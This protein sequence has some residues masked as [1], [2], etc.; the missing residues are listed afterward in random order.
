MAIRRRFLYVLMFTPPAVLVSAVAGATAAAAS[1]GMFWLFVFGD[2]PWPRWSGPVIAVVAVT[3]FVVLLA[4]QLM[5]AWSVGTQQ[6]SKRHINRTH[7]AVAIVSTLTLAAFIAIRFFAGQAPQSHSERS[8]AL[9]RDQGFFASGMPPRDSG[10][11]TCSCYDAN[12]REVRRSE[13]P[14]R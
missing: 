8:A 1:A 13:P 3:A 6:E 7:V 2:N 9:C 5:V 10:D 14:E 12:G 11:R 4:A